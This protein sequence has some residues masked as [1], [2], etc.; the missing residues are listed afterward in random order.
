MFYAL[1]HR[2]ETVLAGRFATI[3]SVA[4]CLESLE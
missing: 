3:S 4:Q 2:T 1:R